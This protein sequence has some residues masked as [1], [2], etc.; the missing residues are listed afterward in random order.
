[1]ETSN[2][3]FRNLLSNVSFLFLSGGV[4]ALSIFLTQILLAR[5]LAPSGYGLFSAAFATITL[6]A[7][8][9]VFGIQHAWLKLSG[10]EGHLVAR[11]M[12][13]S[14]KLVYICLTITLISISAWSFLGP[15]NSSFRNMLLGLSPIIISHIFMELVNS[16]FQI[17]QKFKSLA[18]W[19]TIPHILRLSFVVL[20]FIVFGLYQV[21]Y[22][23]LGYSF[24][25]L[26]IS[27]VGYIFLYKMMKA[28]RDD[29]F[30][31]DISSENKNLSLKKMMGHSWPYGTAAFFYL[32][33]LQSDLIIL[34]YLV[35]DT[36]VGIYSAAFAV[37]LSA[38]LIPGIIYQK[39]L[40][41]KLHRWANFDQKK[42][43]TTY[44]A[45]NGLM[46]IL[47]IIVFVLLFYLNPI[48]IPK[49]FGNKYLET[50][51][52]LNVLLLCIPIRFLATSIESPLFTKNLMVIK[53][54]IMGGAALLNLILN[55]VLIPQY[56]YFG[57]AIATV[58][59][60]IFLLFFYL[61]AVDKY[62]FGSKAYSGWS[63][64]LTHSFWNTSN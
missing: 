61:L 3:L 52:I 23:L 60:E 40:L 41:P 33:Y 9:T 54:S 35:N 50:S 13:I 49:I 19:Q 58:I 38:Y 6:I 64:G 14:F 42:L 45:G 37:L 36:A 26:F 22:L 1:M 63:Q 15:H 39:F 4:S 27:I 44:Q 32:I 2:N 25:A 59:S 5:N 16:K 46:L 24:I 20:L 18:V 12:P 51:E 56:S 43:L 47:G 34:K 53:T 29:L 57:A 17:E 31:E 7:P 28:K 10:S 30:K 11:W 55:F 8:L 21:N 62:L 48:I